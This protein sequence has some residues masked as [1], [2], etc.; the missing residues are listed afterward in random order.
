MRTWKKWSANYIIAMLVHAV[1]E[2]WLEKKLAVTLFIDV[3][4]AFDHISKSQLLKCMIDFGIDENLVVWMKF[5]LSHRNIQSVINEY[6]NKKEEIVIIILWKS[7]ESLILL[8]IY[9]GGVFD[10]VAENNLTI[11]FLS[12]VNNIRFIDFYVLVKKISQTLV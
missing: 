12:F 9:I 10:I 8:L 7:L 4:Q 1:Q 5:F 6:D 11:T 3:K 2:N